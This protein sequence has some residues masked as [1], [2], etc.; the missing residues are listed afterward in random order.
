VADGLVLY[1]IRHGQTQWN[2]EGRM[3]GRLDSALTDHGRAQADAHGRT[4]A[5][6][7]GVDRLIVSPSGR[8]RATAELVNAHLAA[9]VDVE[10]ALMERDCGLWSGLTLDEI[11]TRYPDAWHGRLDDPYHHRPPE[12]ENLPD[13]ERRVAGLIDTVLGGPA[14]RVGLVTHGVMSRVIVKCLMRLSPA[15]ALH[16]RHPN[17]L[18]YRLQLGAAKPLAAHFIDGNGPH[19][20]LLRHHGDGTIPGSH[21]NSND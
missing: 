3:Q 19:P 21:S 15:E 9:P 7:G 13:M 14:R 17:G 20:G 5:T 16:V 12:G 18:F 10:P 8:T 4:L 2:V 11:A 1:V 6:Q